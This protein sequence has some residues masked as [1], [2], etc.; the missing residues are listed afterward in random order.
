[1]IIKINKK[2][3]WEGNSEFQQL[4]VPQFNLQNI[5][6]NIRRLSIPKEGC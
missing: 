5:K 1:M 2:I 6:N 3:K 4:I